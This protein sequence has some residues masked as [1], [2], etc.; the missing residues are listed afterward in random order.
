ML[1][2]KEYEKFVKGDL[3]VFESIYN[4]YSDQVLGIACRYTRCRDDANDVFQETFINV[5]EKRKQFDATYPIWPWIKKIA[6]NS[7][8]GYIR[9]NYKIILSDVIELYDEGDSVSETEMDNFLK[10]NVDEKEAIRTMLIKTMNEMPV[11]YRTI[12]N[13][14][15]IENYTHKEIAQI[16]DI[17]ENN[18]RSQF[19]KAKTKMR[20]LL[21]KYYNYNYVG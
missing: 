1:E 17:T 3:E 5:F 21:K 14:F 2:F 19:H 4:K 20:E 12:F 15:A 8:L 6:I 16:L 13:L 18:S 9:K 10:D 11:G 7:S